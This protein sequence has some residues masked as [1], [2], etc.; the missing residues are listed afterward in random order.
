VQPATERQDE[1]GPVIV[2]HVH[3]APVRQRAERSLL[4]GAGS[5]TSRA[6]K[7]SVQPYYAIPLFLVVFSLALVALLYWGGFEEERRNSSR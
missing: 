7:P 4:R 6:E 5:G 2:R 1:L 3:A